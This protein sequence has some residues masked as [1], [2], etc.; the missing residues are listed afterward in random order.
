M[1]VGDATVIKREKEDNI[2]IE[3]SFKA[4]NSYTKRVEESERVRSKY[5]DKVPVI[6]EKAASNAARKGSDQVPDIDKRKYLVPSEIT[7][8]QLVYVIRKRIHLSP[9]KAIFVFVRNV[10]PPTASPMGAVYD[11][12]RDPDGFLYVT[13]SGENTFGDLLT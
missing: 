10:L 7:V 2:N 3:G 13:Y 4:N 12:Y 5:P 11:D 6:V 8:G 9:E 1:T